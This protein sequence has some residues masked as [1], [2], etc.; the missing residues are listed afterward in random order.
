MLL[1]DIIIVPVVS[2]LVFT[3]SRRASF[4]LLLKHVLLHLELFLLVLIFF[5]TFIV[6]LIVVV[7][8]AVLIHE[9]LLGLAGDAHLLVSAVLLVI[10]FFSV[11]FLVFTVVHL[12]V[13]M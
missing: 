4:L 9:L 7:I 11:I 10:I 8:H 6:H 13:S 12:H 1:V 5:L 3:A 2:K